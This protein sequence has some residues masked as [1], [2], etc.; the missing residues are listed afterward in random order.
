MNKDAL[1][2]ANH[3]WSVPEK[4]YDALGNALEGESGKDAL[5]LANY[6][7]KIPKK[8]LVAMKRILE[9]EG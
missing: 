4:V 5:I 2:V 6:I 8:V 7:N 9:I 3:F 1:I